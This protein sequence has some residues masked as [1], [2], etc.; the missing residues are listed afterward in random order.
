MK[1]FLLLNAVLFFFAAYTVVLAQ[2]KPKIVFDKLQHNFGSFKESDG[3]Q[4][5]T[6]KFTNKGNVPLLLTNVRASCGCTTPKW[7]REPVLPNGTGEIEVS[8][9]PKNRPGSFTKSITVSSNAENATVSLRISGTVEQREK[10]LAEL[11]PRKVGNLRA[12]NN[13]ISF[14]NIKSN[15][16]QTRELELINDTDQPVKIGLQSVPNHIIAKINP[17]TI[18][19]HGKGMLTVTYDATKANTFG[20]ASHRIYLSENG[21]RNYKNSIGVSAT[22]N[23]D[24]SALT[25]EELAKAPVAKFQEASFDFGDMIQGD[26]KEHTFLLSNEG[27]S[28]L[29]I[30]N[31]RSS[32]GCT[33]VAPSTKVIAP[34]ET[35]PI[36]VTFNSRGKRG[37]QSKSITV[38]TNDP[39][40]PTST[41]RITSNVK[42]KS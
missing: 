29:I 11:Y 20:F 36:K 25:P 3:N 6:F 42:T 21:S 5:T 31:I 28:D 32:C 37:R 18:P 38:I 40:N 17:E 24:F 26:K 19:A 34:G 14:G 2:E 8:Y 10:T 12:K 33:A 22:I 16:S 39:K 27:K 1:R 7:T 23:E 41:L 9:N 30:R 15:E 4:T 13:Y 35:A